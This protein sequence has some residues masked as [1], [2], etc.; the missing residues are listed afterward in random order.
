M[1]RNERNWRRRRRRGMTLL[2][3]VIVGLVLLLLLIA[4]LKPSIGSRPLA[5]RAVC[6][7]NM[8]GIAQA[9]HLYSNDN[10]EWFPVHYFE[11]E[12]SANAANAALPPNLDSDELQRLTSVDASWSPPMRH[13]VS[14]IGMMGSTP[15]LRVTEETS[16]DVSPRAS[17]PSRSFFLLVIGNQTTVKGFV[18]PES[19]EREDS[20]RNF[21][22]D[23]A[24]S[25]EVA[26]FASVPGIDR[27]DFAGYDHLSYGIRF[28]YSGAGFRTDLD[29]RAFVAA[30]K[31]PYFTAGSNGVAGSQ[32]TSDAR[33]DVV[34]D[35]AWR[36][37]IVDQILNLDA[38]KLKPFNSRNHGGA[39]QVV[40][41]ADGHA[42]FHTTPFVGPRH[43][44]LYTMQ[45]RD[46]AVDALIGFVPRAHELIG[47]AA[48]T[49]GFV[50]P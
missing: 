50:V 36:E 33:S 40:A 13:G 46:S 10:R 5:K 9:M 25:D 30:D 49:D 45:L 12:T 28:P 44:N 11:S 42:E 37:M 39:G 32:T 35:P 15:T 34:P 17:H 47:P 14:W 24:G 18:C 29:P 23:A 7:A 2:E 43:D 31:G 4:L 19:G 3:A 16:A 26:G 1:T 6:R 27:F 22:P 38:K 48:A 8:R 21:G 41:Y 20:L